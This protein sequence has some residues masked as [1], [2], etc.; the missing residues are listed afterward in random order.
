MAE[1]TV[2][3]QAVGEVAE[4]LLDAYLQGDPK[5]AAKAVAKALRAPV[6]QELNQQHPGLANINL[7]FAFAQRLS[8]ECPTDARDERGV[9]QLSRLVGEGLEMPG[10]AAAH[11]AASAE[12]GLPASTADAKAS[13]ARFAEAIPLTQ[14]LM[15]VWTLTPHAVSDF[16]HAQS[17]R[18]PVMVDAVWGVLWQAC[19]TVRSAQS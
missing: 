2:L 16:V 15:R 6:L 19:A 3:F 11:I 4:K 9:P 17:A 5:V 7:A 8:R 10:Q 14:K 1:V 13:N 18:S 12:F